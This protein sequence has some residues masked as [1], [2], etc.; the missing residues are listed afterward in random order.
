MALDDVVK[1]RSRGTRSPAGGRRGGGG[2]SSGRNSGRSSPYHRPTSSDDKWSHDKF[3]RH[4]AGGKWKND[5]FGSGGRGGQQGGDTLSNENNPKIVVENLHYA[6]TLEDVKELF[7]T[8]AGRVKSAEIKYD[9]SGRSTGVANVVFEDPADAAKAIRKLN[10]I[11]LDDQV[12]KITFAP[13]PVTRRPETNDKPGTKKKDA[14]DVFS[15]LGATEAS[16]AA[17]LGPLNRMPRT[18]AVS[19]PPPSS[20]PAGVQNNQSSGGSGGNRG[21]GH[22]NQRRN[23]PKPKPKLATAEDLDMEMDSY[24]GEGSKA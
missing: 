1:Q 10:G 23:Q 3:G 9:V 14:G 6:V 8:H 7:E 5:R 21:Q 17:R 15:R 12:M 20:S 2:G 4:E 13:L 24:M 16:I 22:S 19:T 11:A 18:H